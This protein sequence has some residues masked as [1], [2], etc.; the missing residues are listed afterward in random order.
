MK[1]AAKAKLMREKFAICSFHDQA[2]EF[3][4][5]NLKKKSNG[6]QIPLRRSEF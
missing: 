4:G 5:M 6:D 2:G 3:K 1:L